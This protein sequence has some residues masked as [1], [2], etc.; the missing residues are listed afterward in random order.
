MRATASEIALRRVLAWLRWTGHAVTPDI[1]RQA[2]QAMAE[3][4]TLAKSDLF[5][6]C[7]EHL[8]YQPQAPL[9]SSDFPPMMPPMR[10]GSIIYGDY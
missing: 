10:R 4:M 6:G 3:V 8:G 9:I 2:M 7:L 5:G 1:E